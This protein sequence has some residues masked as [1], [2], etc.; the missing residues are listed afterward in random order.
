MKTLALALALC[1][2]VVANAN[3]FNPVTWVRWMKEHPRTTERIA[4]VAVGVT[5]NVLG[6]HHCEQIGAFEKCIEGYGNRW[7]FVGFVSGV[8]LALF[9]ASQA[10]SS[11]LPDWRGCDVLANA[12]PAFQIA[13]GT[14][15][16]LQ[17]RPRWEHGKPDLSHVEL[18]HH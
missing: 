3:P 10:C 11:D 16:W 17:T 7:Q 12:T 18:V 5:V 14:H 9:G 1:V 15:D 2:P 8:S 6:T 4:A 13:V